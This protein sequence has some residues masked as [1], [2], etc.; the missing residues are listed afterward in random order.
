MARGAVLVFGYAFPHRKTQDFLVEL[1]ANGMQRVVAVCA[2]WRKLETVGRRFP[3][4]ENAALVSPH[5]PRR[6]C[7]AFGFVYCEAAHDDVTSLRGICDEHDVEIAYVAG[8]RILTGEVISLFSG[9]VINFHPARIP[10]ASGLQSLARTILGD[11]EPGI[12][13][14]FID[15][16]VDAGRII[17]F[18]PVDLSP[19][20]TLQS[21]NEKLHLAGAL[22]FRKILSLS[23]LE[24]SSFK[25]VDRARAPRRLES[26]DEVLAAAKFPAWLVRQL[27]N[28]QFKRIFH[29]CEVG[30]IDELPSLLCT[31]IVNRV[32]SPEGWTPLIVACF[33]LQDEV[34]EFLLTAGADPNLAGRNG[35]T[36]L[37]YTKSK[38]REDRLAA[39]RILKLLLQS[40]AEV[41]RCDVYGK[42]VFFYLESDGDIET[43][44]FLSDMALSTK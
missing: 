2:P 17:D 27:H 18:M 15:S 44:N 28:Q 13:T 23:E 39:E 21:I 36:P 14:H 38:I 12:T 30:L 7:E 10:E 43:A 3:L 20:D 40:G 1:A 8:A 4:F 16:R 5:H 35:T 11:L 24:A 6:L 31:D 22:S 25:V 26:Q 33:N 42:D 37:M 41:D 32:R 34:V 29:A 19:E 9:G